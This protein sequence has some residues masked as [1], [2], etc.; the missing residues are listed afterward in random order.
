MKHILRTVL[1]ISMLLFSIQSVWAESIDDRI[2]A[3]GLPSTNA[4]DLL[5]YA[6]DSDWQVREVVAKRQTTPSDILI[7]LAKDPSWQV[8]AAVSHNLKAPKAAIIPLVNDESVDVRFS[9]AH[10][11]YTPSDLIVKLLNDPVFKVRKQAVVNLNV[12]LSVLKEIAAG[13]SDIADTAKK[14]LEKRLID[15]E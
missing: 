5:K 8:R 4:V 2:R 15:G 11:G 14:A 1:L 6:K 13:N 3:A 10:C 12:P 7:S 9:V